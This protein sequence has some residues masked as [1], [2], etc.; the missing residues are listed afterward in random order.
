MALA[1]GA[2]KRIG[3]LGDRNQMNVI[4][5]Q[6]V[7][8]QRDAVALRAFAE[9]FEIETPVVVEQE[10]VLAIVAPLRDV[11]RHTRHHP[12]H[13][14][15]SVNEELLLSHSS[16]AVPNPSQPVPNPSQPVQDFLLGRPGAD[17]IADP[18][19]A[20]QRF[21]H[22]CRVRYSFR[23]RSGLRM[24]RLADDA[25]D[26]VLGQIRPRVIGDGDPSGLLG[27]LELDVGAGSGVD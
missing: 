24:P 9:S 12:G 13:T 14:G 5:H 17:K 25:P 27:V 11:M 6:A 26:D 22:C 15:H 16:G 23:C 19:A 3:P 18:P 20:M 1:E 8:K 7:A 21:L 4:R 2:G 10:D